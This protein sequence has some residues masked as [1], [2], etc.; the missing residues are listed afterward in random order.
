MPFIFFQ[1]LAAV[2]DLLANQH[3][4]C[5]QISLLTL[6]QKVH[7]EHENNLI[8]LIWDSGPIEWK[9]IIICVVCIMKSYSANGAGQFSNFWLVLCFI[10]LL[11]GFFN[12]YRCSA[13]MKI[14][15]PSWIKVV[16]TFWA[17]CQII[18]VFLVILPIRFIFGFNSLNEK[19]SYGWN[20][21]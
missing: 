2:L 17:N 4:Q 8:L 20:T 1:I 12:H 21:V 10:K 18:N 16:I 5:S 11:F 6:I 9:F 15:L 14:K 7:F 19:D 3:S 13:I